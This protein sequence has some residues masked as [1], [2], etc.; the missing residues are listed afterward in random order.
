MKKQ[1]DCSKFRFSLRMSYLKSR[2]KMEKEQM[3]VPLPHMAV[4]MPPIKPVI[5]S[6]TACHTPK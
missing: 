1:H 2:H 4:K 5:V 6:T 3:S